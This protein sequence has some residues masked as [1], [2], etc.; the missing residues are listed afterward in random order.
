MLE[1]FARYGLV[2]IATDYGLILLEFTKRGMANLE[3]G[4]GG[5]ANI[6]AD[7]ALS[8]Q[9]KQKTDAG[10]QLEFAGKKAVRQ[11]LEGI[12][13]VRESD[14]LPLRVEAWAQYK[15]NEHVIADRATVDYAPSS[16]G[17]LTPVS[18]VHRHLID[19]KLLTEN[20][21]RYQPFK[22]FS[23]SADIKFTEVPDPPADAAKPPVK[24]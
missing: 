6:A 1:N 23:S 7:V 2:D 14:G 16:H 22:M 18:V 10:G 4:S 12:L 15:D 17:F 5:R 19:G 3:I 20:L 21:Y 8:F 11:P 9:W 13:W 24:K